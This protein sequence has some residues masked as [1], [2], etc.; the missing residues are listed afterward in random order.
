MNKN[1]ILKKF[2]TIT[3]RRTYINPEINLKFEIDNFK[4]NINPITQLGLPYNVTTT[5]IKEYD[6]LN[7]DWFKTDIALYEVV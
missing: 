7:G 4:I 2:K 3:N 1:E 5:K 6:K